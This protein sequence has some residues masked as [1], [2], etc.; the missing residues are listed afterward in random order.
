MSNK[1]DLEIDVLSEYHSS[2]TRKTLLPWWIK[3]FVWIF[4]IFLLV[5]PVALLMG[6]LG[7]DFQLALYGMETH[8][9]LS[10]SGLLIAFLFGFKGIVS[11]ALLKEKRIAI[12]LASIDAFMGIGI[13]IFVMADQYMTSSNISF[14][15]ELL[16]LIPYAVKVWNIRKEWLN[17]VA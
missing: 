6:I 2:S 17:S 3:V 5:S 9:P 8:E 12:A 13:C 4:L 1:D 10:T 16:L 14:R 7:Y 11:L 15:L